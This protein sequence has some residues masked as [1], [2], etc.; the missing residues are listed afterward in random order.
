[1]QSSFLDILGPL[2]ADLEDRS[3]VLLSVRVAVGQ[4]VPEPQDLPFTGR[5]CI[6]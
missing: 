6:E 5:E 4:T 1:V 3:Y 2:S